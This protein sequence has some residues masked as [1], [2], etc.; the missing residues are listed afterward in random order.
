MII[1]IKYHCLR[2]SWRIKN[3]IIPAI[4]CF[5]NYHVWNYKQNCDIISSEEKRVCVL[6][7]KEQRYDKDLGLFI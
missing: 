2:I 3:F 1:A 6:C 5:F 4:R 7:S